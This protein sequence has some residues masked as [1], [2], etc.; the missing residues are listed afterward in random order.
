MFEAKS[1]LR[2]SQPGVSERPGPSDF[3]VSYIFLSIHLFLSPSSLYPIIPSHD[4]Q[5]DQESDTIVMMMIERM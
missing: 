4:R 3:Q 1:K 2:W 5:A